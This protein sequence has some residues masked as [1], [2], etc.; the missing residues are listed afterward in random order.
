MISQHYRA[1]ISGKGS[2]GV[3]DRE[4][5]IVLEIGEDAD[6]EIGTLDLLDVLPGRLR[7]GV[8]FQRW[9]SD[10]V[11]GLDLLTGETT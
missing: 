9:A 8:N 6:Y 3:A 11:A 5:V 10:V 1:G 4:H 7:D 2:E